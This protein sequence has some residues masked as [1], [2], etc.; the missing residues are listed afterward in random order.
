MPTEGLKVTRKQVEDI[1]VASIRFTGQVSRIPAVFDKL[2]AL[3]AAAGDKMNGKPLV[4]FYPSYELGED[5][6]VEVCIPV[7]EK[8]E[9]DEIESRLIEGGDFIT[10]SYRGPHDGEAAEAAWNDLFAYINENDIKV[11]APSREVY[12][13]WDK[14]FPEKNVTE[15]QFPLI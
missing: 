8:V 15:L 2:L 4:L 13:E 14:E 1:L 11:K 6:D 7:S 5:D 12:L 3:L 9:A 10:T